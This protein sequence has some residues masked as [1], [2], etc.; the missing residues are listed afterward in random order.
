MEDADLAGDTPVSGTRVARPGTVIAPSRPVTILGLDFVGLVFALVFFAWS[1]SPSLLPRDWVFQGIVSGFTSVT[2]YGVGVALAFP[3]RRWVAPR[4]SW[5]RL[6]YRFELASEIVVAILAVSTVISTLLA[7]AN[8]QREV[9]ALMGMPP[10]F[11]IAYLRVGLIILLIFLI[12]L[13]SARGLRR[14]ARAI[15]HLLSVRLRLPMAAAHVIA[16]IVV[17][18]AVLIFVDKVLLAGS[19]DAARMVFAGQNNGTEHGVVQ[20]I[21]VERSGSPGSAAPWDALGLQ[22]RT[23]VAGGLE[24]ARLTRINGAPAREPIRVYAGLESAADIAARVRLV[25]NELDRTGAWDR[26]ILVV[27]GTTGTGWVNPAAAQSLELM[28]NG[29]SAIAAM[30]YSYLPSWVSFLM[31]RSA[32]ATAGAALIDGIRQRWAELPQGHR[33]RL[34]VFGESLGSQSAE[35]AF[36]GL[37]DLRRSVD[38]A[39][40]VGPPNSNRLW[41]E[42]EDRRDPGTREVLP[43]YAEGLIVRFAAGKQDLAVPEPGALQTIS[44]PWPL[45]R[46]LYLQHASDPVVWW[47][48]NLLFTRP[49]WLTESPGADRTPAMRWYP[50]VTF[51]Q[52]SA[53][54]VA[55]QSPPSGHGHNYEDLL[56]YAW[57]AVAAPPGWTSADSERAAATLTELRAQG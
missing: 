3:V 37:G 27:A 24:S 8:W 9:D 34:I 39:L 30:Q 52:V 31:D 29:D 1:L 26:A 23:F 5:W 16:P 55:A 48:P 6:R 51:W 2:G 7:A 21:R 40:F 56:P 28:Y 33:P 14:V 35:S 19:S 57:A 18:A 41:R 38:G 22:G 36:S 4:F 10:T 50:V 17:A 45:P 25:V 54:L 32:A 13:F 43:G 42:I 15:A 49:D 47:N 12:V 11:G 20:P 46:V 53:D 44:D